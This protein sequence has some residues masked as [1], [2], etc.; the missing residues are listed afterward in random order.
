MM[1]GERRR[2]RGV[3]LRESLDLEKKVIKKESHT[4]LKE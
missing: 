1:H 2:G 4:D 3:A